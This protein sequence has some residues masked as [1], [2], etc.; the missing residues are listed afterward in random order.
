MEHIS[1]KLEGSV[2]RQ[3]EKG[4]REFN[5]STKTEFIR[6]AIRSK[7]K[8]LN[9]EREKERAWKALFAAKGA[10]KWAG[11]FKTDKEWHDWRSG[12]GS[13]ELLDYFDKKLA[14]SQ[15]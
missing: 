11:K 6:D 14:V 9:S 12:P 4:I 13:K 3:L 5:Y 8:E 15:K 2:A 7:L 1:L 10:F